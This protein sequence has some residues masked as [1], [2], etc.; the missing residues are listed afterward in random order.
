MAVVE[1][2][3]RYVLDPDDPETWGGREGDECHVDDEILNEDGV[4]TCPHSAERDGEFCVFH[5]PTT[6]KDDEDVVE[7]LREI[8]ET[9]TKSDENDQQNELLG[10]LGARFGT[11]DL[12]EN[13]L[14]LTT[15]KSG[16]DFSYASIEGE[17]DWSDSI[18]NIPYIRFIG[19]SF[20]GNVKFRDVVFGGEI[21][22]RGV[23]FRRNASFLCAEF[24]GSTTFDQAEF[25]GYAN[26]IDTVYETNASFVE[27]TFREL[28]RFRDV[29]F[30]DECSFNQA[31]FGDT[32]NFSDGEYVGVAKFYGVEF[33]GSAY[34]R[35]TNFTGETYFRNAKFSE[36]S[37]FVEVNLQGVTFIDAD[38]SDVRFTDADC[39]EANFESAI[40]SRTTLF[41]ADFRG[42][43]L[44]GAILGDV[45]VDQDTRFLG[46]HDTETESSPHS[47]SLIR[48]RPCC[49]YDP[50]YEQDTNFE[51]VDKAK[52][53]YRALEELGRRAARPRLQAQCFVR[54]QDLQ[55][56]AYWNVATDPETSLR[57]RLIAGSRW[58]RA[59]T[60]ELVILYG[61]SPWRII[62]YSLG[63]ILTFGLLYPLGGWVRTTAT[64]GSQSPVTYA[65]IVEDP[66]LLWKS[67]YHSAMLFATGNR[68]G[69]VMAVNFTGE[70]LTAT[71]ALLGPTLLA[72]LVFVLGRRAAR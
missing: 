70:V 31:V 12:S 50:D 51:D 24:N 17:W 58:S 55:K 64:T 46:H 66:M 9:A 25:R 28:T 69:G 21:N 3:C 14:D 40:M 63:V 26:F 49:V 47:R 68:Y 27:T 60:A 13:P 11:V 36:R 22:F 56:N 2:S 59:R 15:T 71:E 32:A 37:D 8:I 5:Q 41:G 19:A 42:A 54:R 39:R 20:S 48:S 23:E 29:E 18:L 53:V 7:A 57:E 67:I 43:K 72:L 35:G 38:V 10:F 16:L 65:R 1:G 52:S 34:F 6:E 44:S 61:E 4:W 45:R 62:A 30:K 33:N